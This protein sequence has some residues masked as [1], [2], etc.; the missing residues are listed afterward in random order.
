M[1][2]WG[3]QRVDSEQG[4]GGQVSDARRN[5]LLNCVVSQRD[6]ACIQSTCVCVCVVCVC[7]CVCVCLCLCVFVCVFV[8]VCVCVCEHESMQ[9]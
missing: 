4:H 7:V 9:A 5:L 3:G 2:T 1:T 8:C 6:E